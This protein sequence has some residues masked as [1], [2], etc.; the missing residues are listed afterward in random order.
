MS[1]SS[2]RA[3]AP[4][5]SGGAPRDATALSAPDPGHF[6]LERL[7]WL[8]L[9]GLL[10]GLA[11]T[12][13]GLSVARE[14]LPLGDVDAVAALER[15][16]AWIELAARGIEPPSQGLHDVALDLAA[17]RHARR[18][19]EP[20]ELVRV[21]Q[22]ALAVQSL[23]SWFAERTAEVS[24]LRVL[25]ERLPSLDDLARRLEASLEDDGEVKD[26]ATPTLARL[27][28][29]AHSL[30]REVSQTLT[31]LLHKVEW[32]A[33]LSDQQVHRR[34]GR[35]VLAVK[36]RGG[37]RV[38][39]IVH[40]RSQ[41]GETLFVEPREVV[42]AQ[43]KI[44]ALEL[45]MRS[46]VQRILVELSRTVQG[47][48]LRVELARQV[49]GE[50]ER[51]RLGVSFAARFDARVPDWSVPHDTP[52]AGLVLR[53]VRHPLLLAALEAGALES[54]VPIDVRVGEEFDLLVITGPNT[55]GKTLALKTVAVAALLVRLGL[56][57]CCASGSRVPLY[58]GLVVDLG[59]AQELGANL[60]TFASHVSRIKEGL[61]RADR[62]TLV[63]LDELG[64]GTDPDEGA[65]L[66]AAVLEY[67]LERR[68]PTL[69]T[70]HIGKLKEFAF[71]NARVEN[72][73]VEF[74]AET[75]APRYR[76]LVGTPGESKALYIA[77]RL[78]LP[79]SIVDR[80]GAR[81]E[82]RDKETAE[83]FGE[84]RRAR[85]EAERLR[86]KA[87]ADRAGLELQRQAAEQHIDALR[88]ERERVEHSAQRELEARV[89]SARDKLAQAR[90]LLPQVH[91]SLRPALTAAL[92]ETERELCGATLSEQ[93][94]AFLDGL[95]AGQFV[96]VARWRKRC[97][98]LDVRRKQA[99][100]RVMLG[101]SPME[102]SFDE[103]APS[104][105][106]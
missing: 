43:N 65:A 38:Q 92:E 48:I 104:E 3:P 74:D 66:G 81:L 91:S 85:E 2:A 13:L 49:A 53:A 90:A 67:L 7:D 95:K 20:M 50:V 93:R 10:E 9:R 24:A 27:R 62:A 63:L 33:G 12:P 73:S 34:G 54:V 77:R 31:D 21:L 99:R 68:V 46:E 60:S 22:F 59:D 79:V 71:R 32:R 42:E 94:R 86:S 52:R 51:G 100:A 25:G 105:G 55:G 87:E 41:S 14:I 37:L 45:E 18:P 44:A 19:L 101:A 47:A 39:G 1:K 57:V 102:L 4:P 17:A 98:V 29:K 69:V 28:S 15:Q 89:R 88:Q 26:D 70:T 82:R 36:A 40:D 103:L 61:A 35:L 96:W 56:P 83:L 8:E 80:A 76:L 78:G 84:V 5:P 106:G 6:L 16:R 30:Q 75:L 72:A 97:L 23:R 58:R 64:T 11:R